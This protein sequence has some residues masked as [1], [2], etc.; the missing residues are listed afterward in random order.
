MQ[1][2]EWQVSNW[3]YLSC[4][5]TNLVVKISEYSRC[6][7][8]ETKEKKLMDSIVGKNAAPSFLKL[9]QS[10]F[11]SLSVPGCEIQASC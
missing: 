8:A 6:A 3:N 2:T 9:E 11:N 5:T 10:K 1:V 7:G 4:K